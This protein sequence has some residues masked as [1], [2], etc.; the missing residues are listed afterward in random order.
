MAYWGLLT[1]AL[2]IATGCIHHF[3]G[4]SLIW[5]PMLVQWQNVNQRKLVKGTLGFIWHG[6]TVWFIFMTLLAIYA[7]FTPTFSKGIYLSLA[8]MNSSFA[9][10]ATLYGKLIYGRFGASPQWMFFW[11]ISISAFLA[12]ISV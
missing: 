1:A 10:S 2:L 12:F 5:R 11:P 4:G 3:K 9:M 7:H 8:V 6:V